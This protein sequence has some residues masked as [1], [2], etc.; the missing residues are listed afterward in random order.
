MTTE[1]DIIFDSIYDEVSPVLD[2]AID[3]AV[4]TIIQE[5]DI[6]VETAEKV[7]DTWLQSSAPSQRLIIKNAEQ[8]INKH[9]EKLNVSNSNR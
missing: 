7:I 8:L 4:E 1:N 9:K 2:D 3:N 6:S 5:Y